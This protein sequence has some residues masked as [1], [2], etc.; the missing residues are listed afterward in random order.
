M[1]LVWAYVGL[2]INS[3]IYCVKFITFLRIF[4]EVWMAKL[5]YIYRN[6]LYDHRKTMNKGTESV[7]LPLLL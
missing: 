7:F 6:T 4:L 2:F 1:A 3:K 5:G